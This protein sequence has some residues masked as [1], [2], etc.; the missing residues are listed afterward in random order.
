MLSSNVTFLM[1]LLNLRQVSMNFRG[2]FRTWPN[3]HLLTIFAKYSILDIPSNILLDE[4]VL[5]TSFVF[6]RRLQ[7]VLIKPNMFALALCLQDLLVKTNIFVLPIRL[8][9]VFK[10]SCKNVFKK[11]WRCLQDFFKISS[12]RLQNAFKTSS[13][14][15]QDVF[16]T[17]WRRLQGI[18]KTSCKEIFKTFSRR[19]IKSNC[20]C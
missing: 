12:R 2:A 1:F 3:I 15:L 18:F 13:R 7:G 19:I 14:N 16:K 5:K 4:D 17:F 6:R 20:S 9:D 11:F 10:T 8:Q